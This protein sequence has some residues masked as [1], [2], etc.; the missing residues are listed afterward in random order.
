MAQPEFFKS[1]ALLVKNEP[2]AT[3]KNYFKWKLVSSTAGSLGDD[4]Q[5]ENFEIG[6]RILNGAKVQELRWERVTSTI[7][8]FLG[9]ALGQEYVK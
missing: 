6:G 2:V 4:F 7:D 3:W 1:L 5:K 9:E 8:G